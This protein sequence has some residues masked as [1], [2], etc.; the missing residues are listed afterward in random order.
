[1]LPR[2]VF[3]EQKLWRFMTKGL[4]ASHNLLSQT[5]GHTET[6][7]P[8]ECNIM[9]IVYRDGV[10]SNRNAPSINKLVVWGRSTYIS[11]CVDPAPCEAIN[12]V[13]N[14]MFFILFRWNVLATNHCRRRRNQ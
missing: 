9:C 6:G 7:Q 8:S 5:R 12:T 1:M 3:D 14:M 13:H 2:N 11:Y 4:F 10:P